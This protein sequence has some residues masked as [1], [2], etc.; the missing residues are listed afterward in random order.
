MDALFI[1]LILCVAVAYVHEY[2]TAAFGQLPP[3]K[4]SG[5][6]SSERPL[7]FGSS[8]IANSHNSANPAIG[9]KGERGPQSAG[10]RSFSR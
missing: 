1:G 2:G 9:L 3:F 4:H 6:R 5:T 8:Q 10:K 7:Y